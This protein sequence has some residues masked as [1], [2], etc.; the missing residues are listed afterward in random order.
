MTDYS[1][2]AAR[3]EWTRLPIDNVGYL[4]PNELLSYSDEAFKGLIQTMA[5]TRYAGHRNWNDLYRNCMGLNEFVDKRVIE[6]GCGIG[7]DA[8][9]LAANHNVLCLADINQS[10]LTLAARAMRLVAGSE[11]WESLLIQGAEPFLSPE[12]AGRYD[13]FYSSGVL[14]HTPRMVD[15][16]VDSLRYVSAQ[17]DYRLML[18]SDVAFTAMT[19]ERADPAVDVMHSPQYEHW[20]RAM[21]QV[22]HYAD[23]WNE[24]KLNERLGKYFEIQRVTY[25]MENFHFIAVQMRP[26]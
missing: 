18:Y 10:S 25:L 6:F 21:D 12:H 24:T 7:L 22:G 23:W 11:P 14:H 3:A 13:V 9:K 8:A 2:D 1:F 15:I 4:H 19:D 20:L 5:Y 26:R 16:L 17:C